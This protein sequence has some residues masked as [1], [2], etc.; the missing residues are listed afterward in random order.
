MAQLGESLPPLCLAP[1]LSVLPLPIGIDGR[2]CLLDWRI[3]LSHYA[4]D[5]CAR[6]LA[7]RARK[8]VGC[9]FVCETVVDDACLHRICNLSL[10][11]REEYHVQRLEGISG[12]EL[13]PAPASSSATVAISVHPVEEDHVSPKIMIYPRNTSFIPLLFPLVPVPVRRGKGKRR[14]NWEEDILHRC[15]APARALPR[16]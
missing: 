8:A 14:Q 1:S 3:S 15:R 16:R 12:R 6:K 11:T 10:A 5:S 13:R 7:V 4:S 2:R 9:L